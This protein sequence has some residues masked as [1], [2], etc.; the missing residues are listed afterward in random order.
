MAFVSSM[1]ESGIWTGCVVILVLR[2]ID[3]G[4]PVQIDSYRRR[5]PAVN[6]DSPPQPPPRGDFW[7]RTV[8]GKEPSGRKY[9]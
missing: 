6:G 8:I 1:S 5:H 7:M 2:F 9:T 4:Q 3:S